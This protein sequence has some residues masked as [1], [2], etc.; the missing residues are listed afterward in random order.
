MKRKSWM[1]LFASSLSLCMVSCMRENPAEGGR[2]SDVMPIAARQAIGSNEDTTWIHT[3]ADLRAMRTT[4]NYKLANDIDASATANTPFVPIGFTKSPFT[5]S[6]N[7]N[8]KVIDR[9]TING[10]VQ[11]GMFSWAVNA[12]LRKIRLTNVNVTGGTNTGAIAGYVRNVDLKDS[13]VTGT[14]TGNVQG[15]SRLGLVFGTAN[16]FV[17]IERCYA[18]GTVK[19]WGKYVGGFIGYAYATGI[20]DPNDEFR[21]VVQEVFTNVTINPNMPSGTGTVYAGGLI[22]YLVGGWIEDINIVANVRGRGAV[23]GLF[24]HVVNDHP[25]SLQTFI[26]GAIT[27]GLVTDAATPERTGSI[28]MSTGTFA[29]CG[30]PVLWDRETDTGILN[31]A[32]PQPH[33]QVGLTTAELKAA[34]PDPDKRLWPYIVGTYVDEAFLIR[35]P[36]TPACKH[37]SGS[38]GDWDFGTCGDVQKWAANSSTEYITLTRIPNP[39]VQ[40]K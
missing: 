40:P 35:N 14:V 28:G 21:V 8:D 38:D 32:M 39:G 26:R 16:S 6:F 4:G 12:D 27:R 20:Q 17:R 30:V 15:D 2:S 18:T 7:G 29:D 36:G 1:N 9:L 23:G 34:R 13:Y 11:T 5:G 37:F 33:C 31:P 10:G 19:G 24:G 22:G 3:L 25:S